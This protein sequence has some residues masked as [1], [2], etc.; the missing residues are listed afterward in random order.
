MRSDITDYLP[1]DWLLK[2]QRKY[3]IVYGRDKIINEKF[4]SLSDVIFKLEFT[5]QMV[6]YDIHLVFI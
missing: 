4:P 1:I 2:Q 3:E 6:D 5:H